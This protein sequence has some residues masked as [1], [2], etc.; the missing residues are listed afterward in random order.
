MARIVYGGFLHETNTFAPDLADWAAFEAGGGWPGM[1]SGK[2]VWPTLEGSNISAAGFVASALAD[3]HE[4]IPTTWTAA[5]PSAHVEKQC[6]ERIANTILDGIRAALPVDAVYLDLHGAMVAQHVDDGEGELLARVRQ[7]VGPDIPIA[8]SLDLHANVTVQMVAEA[9]IL[10]A[11]RTYPHVDMAETG[12]RSYSLLQRRLST[13]KRQY[14][15]MRRLPFLVP[16]CWQ[17]TDIEPAKSLYRLLEQT[18]GGDVHLSFA[19]GFPAA[20]FPECSPV[21][22]AYADTQAAAEQA[23]DTLAD[24]AEAAESRF[25]GKLYTPD[26]A[27]QYAMQKAQTATKPMVI[28]DAQ[29]NPGAGSNSDTTG[30]LR[31]LVRNNAQNAAIGLIVDPEAAQQAVAAGEGAVLRL[32]LGGKSGIANDQPFEAE[33]VVEKI[34]TGTAHAK[35]PY[36]RNFTLNMGPSACLRIGGVQVVVASQKVQL[37]DRVMFSYVGI[38]P[39]AADI[40][41]VKSAVHFR[42]DFTPMAEEIIVATAPGSM[43]MVLQELPWRNL[44]EGIRIDPCGKA[45][46][47]ATAS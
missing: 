4:L 16:I 35:G 24:A 26:E 34:S 2:A 44:Q 38:D 45:F 18:E 28:A 12:K 27:V 5:S 25:A 11:Y 17:C 10:V 46:T 7:L 1:V 22:W 47:K 43:P 20:D 23:V 30:M 32:A 19:T 14:K 6:Y 3:G 37:A 31:A 15:A 21:V 33:F 41:V 40:L 39:L 42:A 9:D 36:Y 29:D 13:G 8:V